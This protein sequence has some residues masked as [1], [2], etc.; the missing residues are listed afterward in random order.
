MSDSNHRMDRAEVAKRTE[1]AGKLLQKGKTADALEEY[2]HIM[3]GDPGNDVVRQMAA[4]LC[5]S[6]QRIPEATQM[7]GDLFDRQTE[8]GDATRASLTYKKLARF[9]NP[10]AKQKLRFGQLLEN[11][12]RKL[13]VETYEGALDELAKT[14]A[15]AD[16]V[17]ILKRIVA[18]EPVEGNLLRLGELASKLGESKEA[19]A[20][21][22]RLGRLTEA[23]GG[24]SAQWFEKAYAEDATDPQI[25]LEYSKSLLNQGQVGA[26]IFI[27]EPHHKAGAALPELPDVYARALL[28]ANRLS[29]AEPL[30]WEL[31]EQNP[32]RLPDVSNLIGLLIDA[33][34]DPEAVALARK[35][36]QVQRRRGD[37]KSFSA[38]MQDIAAAHRP[39][40]E[41]LEF[42][43]ELFNAANRETDYSQTLLKLFDL[44]YSMSN[45]EKAAECLDRAAEV[46][47]YEPGHQKRLESLAGKIDQSRYNMI[48]SR[49]ANASTAAPAPMRIEEPALGAA[50]LQ[51]LILQAEILV[52][53][54]MKS[55]ALERVQHIRELFPREEERNQ[56]LQR[57]YLAVG[58]TPKY[59]EPPAARPSP[60]A[61]A[62][63]PAAPPVATPDI[64]SFTRVAEITQK[65]YRQ[66]N[67]DAVLATAI[68]EIGAQWKLS[69]CGAILRKPG[70]P[71]TSVKEY[72]AE[73][74]EAADAGV[75]GKVAILAHDQVM[76]K[77]ALTID[78]I[79]KCAELDPVRPLLS[80]LNVISLVALPLNEG[81]R[82]VG[83]LLLLSDSRREWNP[84]NIVLFKTI[85]DQVVMAMNNAGLRRLVKNLS[86]TDEHS[87]LLKRA[88]Y[89]DML[90]GESRRALQQNSPL[91]VL[92]MQFGKSNTML[93]DIGEAA[94]DALMQQIGQLFGAN[95]RQNDLAFRY[96]TT[97]IALVL[98]ES[99]EDEALG[100]L[101]KLRR[102]LGEL[103]M[104]EKD[105]SIPFHAGIAEAVVQT[106]FDAVDIVTEVINRAEQA[107]ESAI[108]QDNGEPVSCRP[109]LASAAVA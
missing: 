108:L 13:A 4:D 66:A 31:F 93:K 23:V 11:S 10:T 92:L 39:S 25:A 26:A 80:K 106:G 105:E 12:N 44:Y 16:A 73:G 28:A 8:S 60:V 62:P 85:C 70:L 81:T 45:F 2:L 54:G 43:G 87:G 57:L 61:S 68:S 99:R 90:L 56:D 7:L 91:T 1:R 49:F 35:L 24:N 63:L 53:Y 109:E 103:R 50:A 88:S 79:A 30:V 97:S 5:L 29:E 78:D 22:L 55:K 41:I 67:A 72:C 77:G 104:P 14:G 74:V 84:N 34:Q 76:A 82:H 52:Q 83:M 107:L 102:L 75:I 20:A 89:L 94:V 48:A 18:L 27:L 96:D 15:E 33:N 21:F 9:S 64:N 3:A 86:V 95:I 69:R 38:M 101:D 71:P 17:E 46:D 19:A 65:L 51:D 47:A 32:A 37:R 100:T 59:T 6:L 42:M 36:E 98:S 40:P 58:L